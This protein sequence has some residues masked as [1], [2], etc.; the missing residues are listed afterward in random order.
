MSAK[1][2][3]TELPE[4]PARSIRDLAPTLIAIIVGIFMVILDSTAVY[5]AIPKLAEDI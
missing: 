5:V 4:Q 2:L 3:N 1:L